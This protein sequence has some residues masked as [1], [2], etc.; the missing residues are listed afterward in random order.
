MCGCVTARRDW[1]TEKLER[2]EALKHTSMCWSLN[3]NWLSTSSRQSGLSL[4]II[5]VY[6]IIINNRSMYHVSNPSS[7]VFHPPDSSSRYITLNRVN[8]CTAPEE[9][10]INRHEDSHHP[11]YWCAVTMSVRRLNNMYLIGSNKDVHNDEWVHPVRGLVDRRGKWNRESHPRVQTSP[12]RGFVSPPFPCW[13]CD[14][15]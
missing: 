12:E 4:L 2:G 1:L 8:W 3:M 7:N 9:G 5:Y 15:I 6:T 14:T 11:P 10:I 13:T